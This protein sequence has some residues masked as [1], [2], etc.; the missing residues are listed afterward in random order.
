[1]NKQSQMNKKAWQYKSDEVWEKI[2][3]M[4]EDVAEDMKKRPQYYLRRHIEFLGDLKGKKIINLLGSNGKKA[5]PLSLLGSNVT[6]ID[7]SESN[8][9]YAM[10]LA[11][12]AGVEINYIVSD[13]M[14]LNSEKLKNSFDVAFLEC[15]ILHYFADLN[16]VSKKIYDLLKTGGK[17]VLNDYHP[18]R[19]ILKQGVANVPKREKLIL[20]GDYFNKD[21]FNGEHVLQQFLSSEEQSEC[22]EVKLRY[23]TMGEII[24]SFASDFIIKKLIE[25]PRF[26]DHKNIPGTFT[27]ISYKL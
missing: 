15:G 16:L 19:K 5:I 1:M 6:I 23:W 21:L 9:R 17:L 20:D 12:A 11:N 14:E 13:L 18:V 22:P 10:D 2:I 24:S 3:G 25:F 7:I 8:K 26:D 27:L 4:P